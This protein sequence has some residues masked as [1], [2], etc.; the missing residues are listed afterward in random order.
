MSMDIT[1]F[2]NTATTTFETVTGFSINSVATWFSLMMNT[3]IG[4]L[5][6]FVYQMRWYLIS[7]IIIGIIVTAGLQA[8]NFFR[9]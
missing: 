1:G 8:W 2:I 7:G 3:F 4:T 6:A 5:L 9:T